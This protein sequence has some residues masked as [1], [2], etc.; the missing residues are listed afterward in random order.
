MAGNKEFVMP[1]DG[2]KLEFVMPTDGEV[3]QTETSPKQSAPSQG[4]E[5]GLSN[6]I[7]APKTSGLS[8]YTGKPISTSTSPLASTS[9]VGVGSN[10]SKQKSFTPLQKQ[11][12]EKIS[13]D[14]KQGQ[15]NADLKDF[16]N[17]NSV[18]KENPELN[19][20]LDDLT[21]RTKV[22][23]GL[24]DKTTQYEQ[25]LGKGV[26]LL[27][28]QGV[29]LIEEYKANPT[30]ILK[31]Q[32][33]QKQRNYEQT[34]KEYNKQAFIKEGYEK[35]ILQTSDS[36]KK[37]ANSNVP[38]NFYAGLYS[39][40][41]GNV[42]SYKEA[43][44][45]FKKSKI[46]Q[47]QYAKDKALQAPTKEEGTTAQAGEMIGGVIPDIA[48][49]IGFSLLGLPS[50]GVYS[51]AARQGAQQASDDFVRA[52]N[53]AKTEGVKTDK[54]DANGNPIMREPTDDEAYD[55]ATNAAGV[56]GVTGFVEGMVGAKAQNLATSLINRKVAGK[57]AQVIAN[58]IADT[59]ID[60]ATAVGLQ[61][62]R[63]AYDNAQGLNTELSE[64][65]LENAAGEILLSAPTNAYHGTKE[66]KQ[67]K[68]NERAREIFESVVASK[69]DPDAL[70]KLQQNLDIALKNKL[71]TEQDYVD[72]TK[73][74]QEYQR[75][76]PTIPDE[77]KN[78]Q[79][80]ADLIIERDELEAKKENTDKAFQKPIDEA[81][82]V[83][84]EKITNVD[85]KKEEFSKPI[86][87]TSPTNDLYGYV[88]ENGVKRDLTKEEFDN[89]GKVDME[90]QVAATTTEEP[91][92]VGE[93]TKE[94]NQENIDKINYTLRD[95]KNN[96][97]VRLPLSSIETG[98]P[99]GNIFAEQ[100]KSAAQA[101]LEG[102]VSGHDKENNATQASLDKDGNLFIADGRHR[103]EAQKDSG[104]EY[105]WFEVPKEQ[106][107]EIE[108]KYEATKNKEAV[109]PSEEV[110][111]EEN[112]SEGEQ[113]KAEDIEA[114]KANIDEEVTEVWR[115][116][117]KFDEAWEKVNPNYAETLEGTKEAFK[118]YR[119]SLNLIEPLTEY[120]KGG[121]V[122]S[123]EKHSMYLDAEQNEVIS[124]EEIASLYHEAK[125]NNNN[126]ELIAA[127][128]KALSAV[129]SIDKSGYRYG[130]Y[131][132]QV[133]EE[134]NAKY[135]AE[136]AKLEAPTTKKTEA[137]KAEK[138]P[139]NEEAVLDVKNARPI[140]E[141]HV[142]NINSGEVVI[143][144]HA[145]PNGNVD[146]GKELGIHIGT[147]QVAETIK[148]GRNNNNGDVKQVAFRVQKP[149]ILG[150]MAKWNSIDILG[151]LYRQKL[152]PIQTLKEIKDSDISEKEKQKQIIDIIKQKGYDSIAYQ[153][154]DEGNG[155]YSYI[156]FDK[157]QLSE[158][159]IKKQLQNNNTKQNAIQEQSTRKILQ[160]EQGKV[161]EAG[162][163][164][165]GVGD[166]TQAFTTDEKGKSEPIELSIEP[167]RVETPNTEVGDISK[168]DENYKQSRDVTEAVSKENPDASIL[169][170]PKGNDLNLTAVYV[171]KEKRGKGI[172]SKVLESV[173]R[174]ADKLGKKVVLD[175]TNELD[176]ETNLEKLGNFYE[177]NGFVKVGE[178]KFE[179]NPKEQTLAETLVKESRTEK[180]VEQ[181]KQEE[182]KFTDNKSEK[183]TF[184]LIEADDLQP[185]H[186]P[187]GER[188]PKHLIASAQP[189][190]RN[191][192]SSKLVQDKI[193]NDPKFKEVSDSP[194]AYFG[195]PII[196]ERGEVIQGNNRSIGLKKHYAQGGS[197]YKAELEAN[198]E[199]Y[200][201]TKEQVAN[202]KN[203]ILVR[204]VKVSDTEAIK[205]GQ[206]DVKDLETGGK[207]NID[208]IATS[209][210]M[211][212]KD[213]SKVASL[214]FEKD[215]KTLKEAIRDNAK[216]LS[217]ILKAHLNPAQM[218]TAFTN[219]G[220]LT[221]KGMDGVQEIVTHFL[222]E[223]GNAVLPEIYDGLPSNVKKGL[224]KALPHLLSLEKE[225]SLIEDT[226]NAMLALHEFYNSGNE[227]FDDWAQTADI[228]KGVS[229]KEVFTPIEL[230]LAKELSNAK[231]Q[232]AIKNIYAKYEEL[233]AGKKADMFNEAIEGVS[234]K[235]AIK[236]QFKIDY[237][238]NRK[239]NQ[240]EANLKPK[241][242]GN[243]NEPAQEKAAQE[244]V[245]EA[246]G[247]VV[248]EGEREA[249][250]ES[251]GRKSSKQ[252]QEEIA[253][254]RAKEQEEYDAMS[255][256]NDKAKRDEIYDRYD[257]LITP[258]LREQKAL[259][260]TEKAQEGKA[261]QDYQE[262]ISKK[263]ERAKNNAKEKFINDNFDKIVSQL[264]LENKIKRKC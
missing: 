156:L 39:G 95:N 4:A 131:L 63:N 163:E 17:P 31:A 215:Y 208:P 257:E 259:E 214:L 159:P 38:D 238:E 256:P 196:N 7:Q 2:E 25:E 185:S 179:Y 98:V 181:G 157:S 138:S 201:L 121:A 27:K 62:A 192:K 234:K 145:T 26:E 263:S 139:V 32:I 174:Q 150:D 182:V 242:E 142:A 104:V 180:K 195:A 143:G 231:T 33:E 226:Q 28:Q 118:K 193:A 112:I 126:P 83:I 224:E 73:K 41:K 115:D 171:G 199:K 113:Q 42:N 86:K 92:R 134:I 66:Y 58:K 114:K 191:D 117:S 10:T 70:N 254:L 239:G 172:G 177:K 261:E 24:L 205:L 67:A 81:L 162:S 187:S 149:L 258:L 16:I 218:K 220:E 96:V 6:F 43:Y 248:L 124:I 250:D 161:G 207:Q 87:Y 247:Q 153:N 155:E 3:L 260:S 82:N 175:A 188:N 30:P 219:E 178:N 49:T 128:E 183:A 91:Q 244:K 102:A 76:I 19:F 35:R 189:K 13:F 137:S 29:N 107:K 186:L 64:G 5:S 52:F 59:G 206:H 106:A 57:G 85:A 110:A 204:E 166:G 123:N 89:Y 152:I 132:Q 223:D 21:L 48:Q 227:Y 105:G 233:V 140:E 262:A 84:N 146:T 68:Q 129:T 116:E 61:T 80:A 212:P 173:K 168:E 50:V 264:M 217:A 225:N 15:A 130:E 165:Q 37:I 22:V 77:I 56:G 194:N 236:Q 245:N 46:E 240:P 1:S 54:F 176:E 198:A 222:F 141:T 69:D 253:D 55:I 23:R 11:T 147:K 210:K 125:K 36:I 93:G 120:F 243:N 228:F 148:N 133:K 9:S 14:S 216:E 151:E 184:R 20:S 255:D 158:T 88:E 60:A 154:N 252:L 40:M 47:I 109:V 144:Y 45:L 230:Y 221:A 90:Q 18:I 232:G 99:K 111:M 8:D 213:K 127:V 241:S 237:D 203:P 65:L 108:S 97:L 53:K 246:N 249:G 251:Q 170:T 51:V 235:E 74:T 190:E 78:K 71:I 100:R 229:P 169:I 12:L 167:S 136:L 160:R 75:V 72:I 209:R 103:V 197:K 211:S 44:D 119:N 135:D 79:G 202:M 164:R 122:I 94:I 200:G 34:L 101:H